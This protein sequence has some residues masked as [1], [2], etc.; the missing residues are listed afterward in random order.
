MKRFTS[1]FKSRFLL[2]AVVYSAGMLSAAAPSAE[3]KLRVVTTL[4]SFAELAREVGGEEVDASSMVKGSQDPHFVDPKPDL[5]LQLHRADLLIRVGLGLEDGWLP[6]LLIGSRNGKIQNGAK[7]NLEASTLVKLQDVPEGKLDRAQ[8]DVHPGGNPHFMLD[9]RIGIQVAQ[10]IAARLGELEPSKAADFKK[11]ADA[12]AAQ[13]QSK[14][15]AWEAALKPWAGK[16]I[17]TYH[18]SFTYFA[19]WIGLKVVDTVEPKPGIPPSPEHVVKLT[20][21]MSEQ[22]I[23]LI[24]IEP[25]YPKST[26]EEVA[27]SSGAKL[28]VIPTE[29]GGAPEAGSYAAI[30]DQIVQRF[31]QP[32][33]S[34]VSTQKPKAGSK[35]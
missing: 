3:A 34:Q 15:Q 23:P 13:L 32:A 1:A 24:L 5:V 12:F 29:V 27:K 31:G 7:G 22:K 21:M 11:R 14:I 4:P 20:R 26:S 17:V 35:K 18:K 25:Y 19:S 2:I 8:G 6:P 30:F 9:P 10:G 28:L 16:S 33:P